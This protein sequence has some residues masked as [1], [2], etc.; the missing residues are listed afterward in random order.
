M[1]GFVLDGGVHNAAMLRTVLPNPPAS[2][3]SSASLHRTHIPPLDTVIALALPPASAITEA[4]GPTTK[5]KPIHSL[6]DIPSEI[7]KSGPTGT[8]LLTWATPDVPNEK[9]PLSGMDITTTNAQ[10]TVKRGG[11]GWEVSVSGA[12]GSDVEDQ[13]FEGPSEGVKVEIA[14][15]GRAVGEAKEGKSFSEEDLGT[16]RGALWDL[17]V[18]EACL[19]SNGKPVELAPL[20]GKSLSPQ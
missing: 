19:T 1:T 5:L 9:K 4:H 13:T 8:I 12:K 7:G 11:S 2:I 16:P 6:S 17:A 10:I 20:V 15:F 3:I 14:M 18:I